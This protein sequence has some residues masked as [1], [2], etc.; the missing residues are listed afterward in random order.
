MN[1]DKILIF[2]PM[3][4][5]EKQISRVLEK[6]KKTN[7]KQLLFSEIIIVDN[8]SNDNSIGVAKESS[9]KCLIPVKILRNI[10]N[11]GLGGSHK[12]AFEYAINNKFDYVI[13]LHG[14]DQGDINDIIKYIENNEYTKYDSFLGSRFEK[15]SKLINYSKFRIFGNIVFNTIIS[16]MMKRKLTDLGSGLNMYKIKYLEKRFFMS[17]PNNLTFN[18][19]MLL[20]GLFSKSK[21][22]F[23]ALSWREDDQVSNAKLFSQSR[24]ILSLVFKYK[25]NKDKLF[26]VV[27]NQYSRLTYDYDIVYNY[28]EKE[29]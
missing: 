12:V 25:I 11:R 14:D 21:F 15:E 27:D 1:K 29:D 5:C 2:I 4:N 3:Y 26:K 13:V 22:D 28:Q 8:Q 16:T 7:E 20:Y 23:F 18:V 19:Y 10:E 9:K 24:E 17:F 6:I